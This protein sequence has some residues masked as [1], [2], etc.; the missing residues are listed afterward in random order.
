VKIANT[1]LAMLK[2]LYHMQSFLY[3]MV[4]KTV[5]AVV[6]IVAALGLAGVVVVEA[7]SIVK[8]IQAF[9]AGYNNCRAANASRGR[10][11]G[12]GPH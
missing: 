4:D 11:F 2:I 10:C 1:F 5:L 6:A 3:K 9:A 7:D 8:Q 12:H